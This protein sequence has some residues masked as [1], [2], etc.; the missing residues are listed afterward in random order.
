MLT[1]MILPC[2]SWC[3]KSAA[4]TTDPLGRTNPRSAVTGFL[5]ACHGQNYAKAAQYLNL[6]GIP[7]R[8]RAQQGPELAR[9]LEAILNSDSQFDALRLSQSSQGNL[10][11]DQDPNIEH[12]SSV[13]NN[14][15]SF[16]LELQKIQ[17]V[18][19]PAI[20]VFSRRT[21]AAIPKLSPPNSTES[22]IEARLPRFLVAIHFLDTPVWKWAALF[23]LALLVIVAFRFIVHLL[24][25]VL[26]DM[27]RRLKKPGSWAWLRA[28]LE[29]VLVLLSVTVFRIAEQFVDPSALS[30][31]YIC[32]GLFLVVIWSIAWGAMNLVELFLRRLTG[33]S[34][35]GQRVV[36][37]SLIYLARRVS[38]AV[39]VIF[40]AVVTL[41]NWGYDMTTIIA[42][43]GVG[44][45]AIALAAQQT[46]ANVFG[47]VSVIGDNPVTVG[48][49]ETS[50]PDR[51]ARRHRHAVHPRSH[52]Q[53]N[54]PERTE[55]VLRGD[56]FRDYSLRDKI[57][58]NP[59]VQIKRSVPK[60]QIRRCMAGLREM[61]A[62]NRSVEIGPT[63]VR[64][65]AYT[66]ASFG[67][68]LFA[69]VLTDDINEF[70]KTEAE[71]FLEMD[72]VITAAG[73]ELA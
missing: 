69:Y 17:P 6:D 28:V 27:E 11:D 50:A 7:L 9:E 4:N 2:T 67:I 21:V 64:I 33:F 24:V 29:P 53:Q 34:S 20:W 19:A 62:K 54:D 57:L 65:S 72:D 63:P 26:G 43:L 66:S 60:D 56:E 52:A 58:F 39:I 44:G 14:G 47:G 35:P 41:T 55:L 8:E 48:D 16:D 38:K 61:L 45:I 46:L 30:R 40:A 49:F 36:S 31:L 18:N 15:E 37:H 73:V 12:V 5:E 13:T 71:L 42:G 25:L 22:A 1:A 23:S 3:Q 59:T 68:E 10:S 32:R 51:D 70:Y